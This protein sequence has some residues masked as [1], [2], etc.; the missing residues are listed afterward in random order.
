MRIADGR[1]LAHHRRLV[2]I[3][4]LA[5]AVGDPRVI[6]QLSLNFY[7]RVWGDEADPAFRGA[8]QGSAGSAEEAADNQSRWLTEMWGG[9][10]LYAAKHGDGAL[11]KRMLPKHSAARM[12]PRFCERWL[13]HMRAAAAEV[14][15]ARGT[16]AAGEAELRDTVARYWLHFFGF[17]EMSAADR[18]ALRELADVPG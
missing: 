7:R 13:R 10:A 17:F 12:T 16:G 9:E 5:A 11:L 15:G 18:R 14:L 3:K 6:E 1:A 2:P 8:F 4:G